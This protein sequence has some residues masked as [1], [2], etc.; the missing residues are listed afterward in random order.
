[1]LAERGE[2]TERVVGLSLDGTG[3][4]DDGTIWGG[5]VFVGS[6]RD[7]LERVAHLRPAALVGGDAAARHPVQA[8]VGFIDQLDDLPDLTRMPFRFPA[9]Y[10]SARRL[11]QSGTRVFTTTSA[12]RLFDSAAALLG[13]TFPV[14]FEG[15]AAIWMEHLAGGCGA[16]EPFPFPMDDG[17]LDWRP[18]L[19]AV[20][21]ERARG[22][23]P[24]EIARAFH[25]GMAEGLCEAARALGRAHRVHTIVASGGVF[26]NALLTSELAAHLD[27]EGLRL[28]INHAVP[29]NDG[30]ISLGQA[31]L[32][33]LG[34]CTNFR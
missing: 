18:L 20:A 29:P 1:V 33:A 9:R 11:L 3:Y 26:Q 16:V 27:R 2:W 31:A 4:G 5:E 25:A 32:G 13:F 30:G 23:D 34:P 28:W 24:G 12:G 21:R 7:G 8:A 6:V 19:G 17:E 22:R 10:V 15:Q 14:T